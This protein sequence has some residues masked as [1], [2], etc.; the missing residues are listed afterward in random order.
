MVGAA[1]WRVAVL[2][3]VRVMVCWVAVGPGTLLKMRAVGLRARPGSG[4]PK[5]VR[6][7]VTVP[8]LV[9]RVRVPVRWPVAV[10]A[11]AMLRKQEA[12]GARAPLQAGRRWGVVA[13]GEVAGEGGGGEGDGGGVRLVRVKRVGALVLWMGTGPKSCV[14]GVRRRPVRGRPVPVRVRG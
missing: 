2:V 14:V 11:K 9:W 8:W 5:P 3:L 13:E 4:V 10:G 7:A 6:V 12:V 1:I